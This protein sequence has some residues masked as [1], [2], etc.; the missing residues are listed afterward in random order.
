MALNGKWAGGSQVSV[1]EPKQY[2][3]TLKYL[4]DFRIRR[5]VK[6]RANW[7]VR[8][9]VNCGTKL[10]RSVKNIWLLNSDGEWSS[11]SL[12]SGF[13]W[14][15]SKERFFSW[16]VSGLALTTRRGL[17]ISDFPIRYGLS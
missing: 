17:S 3:H 10:V 8:V 4:L 9:P 16:R 14:D 7:P 6:R 12:I 13:R 2:Y 11:A 15:Y 5:G 1:S